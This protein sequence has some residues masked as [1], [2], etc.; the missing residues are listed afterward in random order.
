MMK[1]NKIIIFILI[2][3]MLVL[4]GCSIF[5]TDKKAHPEA[6]KLYKEIINS[7]IPWEKFAVSVENLDILLYETGNGENTTLILGGFHGNER[8]GAELVF[9]FAKYL[10]ENIQTDA[11]VVLVPLVNPDG[12]LRNK[13]F[14]KNNTD[15]N[16]NF[17]TKNWG[18]TTNSF[19]LQP[20]TA[21]ASEPETRAVIEIVKRYQPDKI[22]SV[23]T[24]LRVINYD[25]PA[26]LLAEKMSAI[27]G[28]PSS[29]YIGYPTPGSLGTYAGK[30][31]GI[32]VITIELPI[33][34]FALLWDKNRDAL[35]SAIHFKFQETGK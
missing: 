19:M 25:G 20:G 24:P 17:P 1:N 16:R 14:N 5:I 13:R 2:C 9:E 7:K 34:P 27:T 28:Y 32:P 3:Y 29:T 22:I 4:S 12:L 21:P 11:K 23:H 33:E 18:M 26:S 35:L 10:S 6:Y 30:E 15:I 8:L 31:M